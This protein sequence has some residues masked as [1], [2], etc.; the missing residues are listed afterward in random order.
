MAGTG[1]VVVPEKEFNQTLKFMVEKGAV[2]TDLYK[3]LE[4]IK[5]IIE[6]MDI[7]ALVA[8]MTGSIVEICKQ[9]KNIAEDKKVNILDAPAFIKIGAEIMSGI[10]KAGQVR[11][12]ITDLSAIEMLYVGI[13][14]YFTYMQIAEKEAQKFIGALQV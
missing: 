12:E 9:I 5:R 6:A 14:G 11:D 8:M 7:D 13:A 10:K 3:N 4:A 1:F 2:N